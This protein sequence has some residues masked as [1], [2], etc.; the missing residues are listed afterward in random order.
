[1]ALSLKKPHLSNRSGRPS[2]A[3]FTL[4]SSG[5]TLIE[6][7]VVIAIIAILA[8][9]LF[10]VFAQA[11]EKARQTACLSNTKQLSLG[12]MQYAQDYD[13]T[14]PVVGTTGT[15]RGTWM[16][17]I[18]SY[19][20]NKDVFSCPSLGGVGYSNQGGVYGNASAYGWN[21]NLGTLPENNQ[22]GYPLSELR[23]PAETIIIGD[24]GYLY[25]D[26]YGQAGFALFGSDP[27]DLIGSA[28]AAS[29]VVGTNFGYLAKFRHMATTYVSI[30]YT[31]VIPTNA[32]GT[33]ITT[34]ADTAR[35]P[36][37]GL[38]NFAFLDGHSK[39]LKAGQA[40][41]L[42]PKAAD[43]TYR[44]DNSPALTAPAGTPAGS[45]GNP[46]VYYKYWNRH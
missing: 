9:I 46:N 38:A 15:M 43:G 4:I 18:Y 2:P 19:V 31:A 22:S 27:R 34:R 39:A 16:T 41:E 5:F 17:Q 8:A 24:D 14:L 25:Q 1:M 37:D 11:R 12:V 40:F 29:N 45:S 23:N 6:L 13:E 33:T 28:T 26:T 30:P 35:M 10:P 36:V 42:A 3:A 21:W 32:A 44:E 7:L 20:A